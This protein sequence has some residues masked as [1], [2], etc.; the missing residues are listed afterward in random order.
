MH[1]TNEWQRTRSSHSDQ[2]RLDSLSHLWNHWSIFRWRKAYVFVRSDRRPMIEDWWL[3]V[4]D[5]YNILVRT[6]MLQSAFTKMLLG[7]RSRWIKFA[8]CKYLRALRIWYMKNWICSSV[9]VWGSTS[10]RLVH[11]V[12][13]SIKLI[14]ANTPHDQRTRNLVFG[15]YNFMKVGIHQVCDEVARCEQDVTHSRDATQNKK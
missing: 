10:S 5:S 6:L 7:V 4:S 1:G 11:W 8:E 13:H 12:L 3:M 2:S 15:V 9:G 14:W